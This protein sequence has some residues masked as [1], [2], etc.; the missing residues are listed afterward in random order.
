MRRRLFSALMVMLLTAVALSPAAGSPQPCSCGGEDRALELTTPAM[1]GDNANPLTPPAGELRLVID[2]D[3]RTLT[4]VV[5]DKPWKTFPCA[6]G[7]PSTKSPVGD[8]AVVYKGTNWGGGFGTRWMGLNVPWGIY[9]IHGTNKPGSIG[10][11]ASGGCIRMTNRDV[12][13][14]YPLVKIGTRVSIVGAYPKV[15][16]NQPLSMGRSGKE[17]QQVQISLRDAGFVPGFTDGRFGRDTERA[18]KS[19]QS[20]YGLPQTGKADLNVLTL[21]RL[22]R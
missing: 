12:E 10:T 9:G 4:V 22:R 8:W 2:V 20:F 19:L 14:L 13:R 11:A 7:K 1:T 6:V 5:D 15:A 17:V 16:V 18:I 21:L 3:K